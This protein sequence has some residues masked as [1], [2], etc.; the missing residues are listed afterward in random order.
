MYQPFFIRLPLI[1]MFS[2]VHI[3]CGQ[4]IL[5]H[6]TV[7]D[8]DGHTPMPFAYVADKN[9]LQGSLT[10]ANGAFSIFAGR[11]DT[12]LFSYLGYQLKKIQIRY[13]TD[14]VKNNSLKLRVILQP[15]VNELKP[16]I[17]TT[18]EFTREE[19][20]F[21]GRKINEYQQMTHSPLESP[22]TAMYYAFSKEGKQI[23]KLMALYD[24][25]LRD[26]TIEKRLSPDKIREVTGNDTLNVT[27]FLRFC[28]FRENFILYERDYALYETVK[29]CYHE[30]KVQNGILS[31]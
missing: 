8:K 2:A 23:R 19:K 12:L 10:D 7:F 27:V 16:V 28:S 15:K 6:G 17:I 1:I 14:S 31:K 25:L 21:Y 4:N 3:C 24:Q 20:E 11:T 5:V 9:T 18:N 13:Y 26:E 30:Y 29:N 22:I